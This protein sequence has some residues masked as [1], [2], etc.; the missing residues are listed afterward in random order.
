MYRLNNCIPNIQP[1]DSKGMITDEYIHFLQGSHIF[2]QEKHLEF[3]ITSLKY[4]FS[5]KVSNSP[6]ES[7]KIVGPAHFKNIET[8]DIILLDIH[9]PGFSVDTSK[10]KQATQVDFDYY[11]TKLKKNNDNSK[12][13]NMV[14][15][16]IQMDESDEEDED[17]YFRGNIDEY[18]KK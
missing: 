17:P 4:K 11:Q 7:Y 1:C 16:I 15:S 18:L 10:F 14:Q 13:Y 3:E 5:F 6:E 2:N 12:L 8:G 9:N